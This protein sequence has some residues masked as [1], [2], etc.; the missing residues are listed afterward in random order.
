M[1]FGDYFT[2][3]HSPTHH[4]MMQE[5]YLINKALQYKIVFC[6]DVI[7]LVTLDLGKLGF[8]PN[9]GRYRIDS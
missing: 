7:K 9:R 2:K 6:K 5:T 4:R 8:N 3:H 1:N